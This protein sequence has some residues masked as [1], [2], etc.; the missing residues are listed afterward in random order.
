M[1]HFLVVSGV[2]IGILVWMLHQL[3]HILHIPLRYRSFFLAAILLLYAGLTGFHFPVLRATIMALILYFSITCN[4]IPDPLYGLAFSVGIILFIFPTALFEVSFQLTVAATTSIL[5]LY[6]F[7]RHFPWWERCSHFP[8]LIRLPLMTLLMATGAMIGISPLLV[9]YFRQLYPYSLVSNLLALP[10]I[11]LLL[12]FSLF[13]S[14]LSLFLP[15]NLISPLLSINVLL[16]KWFLFLTRLFPEFDIVLPQPTPLM[17][18]IYYVSVYCGLNFY[19][20]VLHHKGT[21]VTKKEESA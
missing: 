5:F 19:M 12:P 3:L 4:R 20:F 8:Y 9:F 13:S 21:R 7:L 18:V 6:R 14:T 16:A 1:Y 2:H 17:L 11:S 10:V 15:W